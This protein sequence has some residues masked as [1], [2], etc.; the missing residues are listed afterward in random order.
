MQIT[1]CD[2]LPSMNDVHDIKNNNIPA[3]DIILFK[4]SRSRGRRDSVYS[5]NDIKKKKK[6]TAERR[7]VPKGGPHF[8]RSV[9]LFS[10]KENTTTVRDT[11]CF[12]RS[13]KHS[14]E[15]Y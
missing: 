9:Y 7:S 5:P 8:E 6:K 10:G 2:A 13:Y 14:L 3:S 11:S 4:I 15:C 12:T 1:S